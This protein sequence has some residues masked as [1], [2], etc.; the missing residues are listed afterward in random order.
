MKN[1][2]AFLNIFFCC[3]WLFLSSLV[4]VYVKKKKKVWENWKLKEKSVHKKEQEKEVNIKK[5]TEK[6]FGQHSA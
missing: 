3:S 5:R 1:R 2:L 6:R 4:L